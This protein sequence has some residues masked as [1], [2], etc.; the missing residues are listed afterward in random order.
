MSQAQADKSNGG[1]H[2]VKIGPSASEVVNEKRKISTSGKRPGKPAKDE[3]TSDPIQKQVT[4]NAD[5]DGGKQEPTGF[6]K[7]K[8]I[9]WRLI[10]LFV[11]GGILAIPIILGYTNSVVARANIGGVFVRWFFVWVEIFWCSIWISSIVAKFILPGIVRISIGIFS[12]KAKKYHYVVG[13]LDVPLT[14]LGWS[15]ASF[16]SFTPIMH[17]NGHY[18][19]YSVEWRTPTHQVLAGLFVTAAM[20]L[21]KSVLIQIVYIRYRQAQLADKVTRNKEAIELL[22][23]LYAKSR[24]LHADQTDPKFMAD[25]RV[26]AE[27]ITFAVGDITFEG[28][29]GH[30]EMSEASA[31]VIWALERRKTHAPSLAKRIWNSFV[32]AGHHRLIPEDLEDHFDQAVITKAFEILDQD[33][34][35]DITLDEMIS[36]IAHIARE[37]KDLYSG[38]EDSQD[39]VASFSILCN[40]VVAGLS[41]L[42]FLAFLTS[43]KNTFGYAATVLASLG[44]AFN[45]TIT[46]LF[47]AVIFI[48]VKHP[49]DVGDVVGIGSEEYVVEHISLL[50]TQVRNNSNNKYAHFPNSILN[51]KMVE[52][53]SRSKAMQETFVISLSYDTTVEDIDLL[54]AELRTF[55]HANPRDFFTREEDLIVNMTGFALDKVDVKVQVGYKGNYADGKRGKR[56]AMVLKELLRLTRLIPMYGPGGGGAALGSGDNPTFGVTVTPDDAKLRLEAFNQ[57]KEA[58]KMKKVD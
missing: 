15:F 4:E 49:F 23:R 10:M 48:F 20:Y 42:I 2:I 12:K 37:R 56:K 43:I 53:V 52:N 1:D 58:N 33:E 30:A 8:P 47:A 17:A 19:P 45:G 28:P 24:Q 16:I 18:E 38:W 35:G 7:F 44:F 32:K 14:L 36:D 46:E 5:L 22:T 51:S 54:K 40:V 3:S 29:E 11:P 6:K 41:V 39:I 57:K 27:A 26:L 9:F 55:I 13:A 21:V 50:Y 31:R 25:D 34:N